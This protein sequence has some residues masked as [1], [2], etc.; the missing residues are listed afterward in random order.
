MPQTLQLLCFALLLFSCKGKPEDIGEKDA[1]VPVYASNADARL[2]SQSGPQPIIA[3]GKIATFDRY[4]FQVEEGKGIHIID[5]SNTIAPVKKSFIKIPQCHELTVKSG[6]IYTNNLS[7][8]V[9]LDIT[10]ITAVKLTSRIANAFP[11]LAIQYPPV[12]GAYFV[13]ADPAKGE[14][15]AWELKKVNNPKCKRP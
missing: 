5:Y 7:D 15:V 1:W 3:G 11:D 2:I 14:V 8:L 4:V 6:Y 13:C 9:V 12:E 10:N